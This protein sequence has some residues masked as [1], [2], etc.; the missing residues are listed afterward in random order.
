MRTAR[1]ARQLTASV[2][3]RSWDDLCRVYE[4]N[5]QEWESC[6]WLFRGQSL[7][8][9]EA[10]E[11]VLSTSLE[12]ALKRFGIPLRE[13][14]A[15]E[16]SLLR[17]FKRR[18]HL[19]TAQPPPLEND[20]E[21]LALLRHYGGPARLLDWTYSYWAAIHFAVEHAHPGQRCQMWALDTQWWLTRT[22]YPALK[23]VVNKY[24][25][26]SL[27]ESREVL[28]HRRRP[29]IWLLNPFRLN[30]RLSAQQGNFLLPLDITRPLAANFDALASPGERSRHLR[31]FE[32]EATA[33]L[34]RACLGNLQRMNIT[35]LTLYPGLAGL[36]RH[37]ENAVAMPHLFQTT[38]R[39]AI[40][41][42]SGGTI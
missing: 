33:D 29:G 8:P 26:N 12:R 1:A 17:D 27:E 11:P 28:K 5:K 39:R 10:R 40:S 37:Y 21:W 41:R 3:L 42:R 19:A 30:D 2:S 4:E 22:Q 13:A 38:S 23:A 34:L 9:S 7:L 25:S 31:V 36:A 32:L 14:P 35:R 20:L 16:Y 15:W 6:R 18:C 24:G